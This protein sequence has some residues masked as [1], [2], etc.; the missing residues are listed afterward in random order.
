MV[1]LCLLKQM[2]SCKKKHL[3]LSEPCY[4]DAAVIRLLQRGGIDGVGE[5]LQSREASHPTSGK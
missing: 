5:N 1:G 4:C 3:Y 2:G